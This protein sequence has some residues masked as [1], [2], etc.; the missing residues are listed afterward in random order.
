[1]AINFPDNPVNLQTYTY[2]DGAGRVVK[3][4]YFSAKDN[5]TGEIASSIQ[6]AK[7][8]PGQVSAQPP[9]SSGTGTQEDPYIVTPGTCATQGLGLLS[10]QQII[11]AGQTLGQ[12]V[13]FN[14]VSE[15]AEQRFQQPLGIVDGFGIYSTNL[16]YQDTPTSS[17]DG[18]IYSGLFQVGTAWL[19]W[20]V[21]QQVT[22]PISQDSATSISVSGSVYKVGA[23]ASMVPGTL[24]GGEPG[25]G[26]TYEYYWQSSPDGSSNTFKNITIP[27]GDV[28][29]QNYVIQEADTDF[30]IRGVTK[31]TDSTIPVN[32]TLV[33]NSAN[34]ATKVFGPPKLNNVLLV[35]D[36]GDSVNRFTSQSYTTAYSFSTD[37]TGTSTRDIK[38]ILTTPDNGVLYGI[39]G[40]NGAVTNVTAIDPGYVTTTDQVSPVAITFPATFTDTLVP[41]EVLPPG[42]SIQTEIKAINLYGNDIKASNIITPI[43][44]GEVIFPT[45]NLINGFT[46][47]TDPFVADETPFNT[48]VVQG[49]DKATYAFAWGSSP[50]TI[51]FNPAWDV[52]AT[53]I[54]SFQGG[55]IIAGINDF[56]VTFVDG[57]DNSTVATVSTPNADWSTPISFGSFT[58]PTTIKSIILTSEN[59]SDK[60]NGII[61]F[62]DTNNAS[63]LY[64]NYALAQNNLTRSK[65]EA[66]D[67]AANWATRSAA[68]TYN[69]ANPST[70]NLDAFI[71]PKAG[72]D[73]NNIYILHLDKAPGAINVSIEVVLT[74]LSTFTLTATSLSQSVTYDTFLTNLIAGLSTDSRVTVAAVNGAITVTP[75]ATYAIDDVKVT[76]TS[77]SLTSQTIDD[78]NGTAVGAP[79]VPNTFTVTVANKTGNNHTYGL[80]SLKAYFINTVEANTLAFTKGLTYRFN[81]SDASNAGH[82]LRF[83]TDAA[84]TTEYTTGVTTNGTPGT[85]GAYT[86]IATVTNAPAILYY[87]C[88]NHAY[89]G[90]QIT[91]S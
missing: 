54:T 29:A 13:Y 87:Q 37:G 66:L 76:L 75:A 16:V 47:S 5:W 81:Q 14:D 69:I 40:V 62:Y 68:A 10:S 2:N 63:V 8:N 27:S 25:A 22:S 74:N 6:I 9:F 83:Y 50:T 85:V 91:L 15:N 48:A 3:Y 39:L 61:N 80:G 34:S 88:S 46:Q 43:V 49:T 38:V 4:T 11:I 45:P 58:P 35:D 57:S 52:S 70:P 18:I 53:P 72:F 32:Q 84:K 59:L 23:T 30:F 1:M 21:T 79:T 86:Q 31:G 33:M 26:Y 42:T 19:S 12:R 51:T 28:S 90:G 71:L 60:T 65:L 73:S 36:D 77:G 41:D 78:V 89:M 55:G 7:P 56:K 67:L 17:V 64:E 82:P 24:T 20:N 44:V